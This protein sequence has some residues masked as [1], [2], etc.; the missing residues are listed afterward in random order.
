MFQPVWFFVG[1]HGLQG[2]ARPEGVFINAEGLI[3]SPD[4]L[5]P[6]VM[7]E[8]AH[9]QQAMVQGIDTYRSIYGPDGTLLA[10]A[11]REGSAELIA[12]LTAGRHI[13]PVAER[14]GLE[15]EPE[16]WA[17]FQEDMHRREPGDW[18]FVQP[19]NSEWPADLG[20]WIGYRIA[21]SYYE[22]AGEKRQAIQDIMSLSEYEAF[23]RA[24]GY[25][26]EGAG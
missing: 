8:L 11:L 17:R 24:S 6:L 20:Y 10:L 25:M 21:K 26:E 14:Y 23:L 19:A 3:D 16:L 9:F 4:E 13:N 15:H 2:L 5:V 7:H 12:E 22:N 1:G 18:M